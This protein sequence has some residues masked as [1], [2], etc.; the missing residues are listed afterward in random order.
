MPTAAA[1]ELAVTVDTPLTV[2]SGH[3]IQTRL[4][5]HDRATHPIRLRTGG[6]LIGLV[7]DPATG[8]RVG[9]A[10]RQ[11]LKLV[12]FHISSAGAATIPFRVTT[13]SL[14]PDLG[15]A[16]PPGRW[17]TQMVLQFDDGRRVKTPPLPLT[18]TDPR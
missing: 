6:T 13:D 2:A 3:E 12:T 10:V 5:V 9:G 7:I 11:T 16:V 17:A 14:I 1:I 8:D 15:Y 18:V 4:T